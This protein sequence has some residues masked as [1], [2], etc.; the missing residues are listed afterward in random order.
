MNRRGWLE[1]LGMYG[2]LTLVNLIWAPEQL[3]FPKAAPHPYVLPILIT[4]SRYGVAAGLWASL[5][6]FVFMF[7]LSGLAFAFPFHWYSSG[8][9]INLQNMLDHPRNLV[10]A[11]WVLWSAAVGSA[12]EKV[13]RE[14]DHFS[15]E[16]EHLQQTHAEVKTRN[17]LLS[18]ENQELREK[19]LGKGDTVATV[20]E[21]A[22]RLT[23]LRGQDLYVACLELVEKFVGSERSCIYL[24]SKDRR[25]LELA[26]SRT[27]E[28][29]PAPFEKE[30]GRGDPLLEKCLSENRT[31]SVRELFTAQRSQQKIPAV[32]SAPLFTEESGTLG[33]LVLEVLPI[34]SLNAQT[35]SVLELLADW[36]SRSL[37]VVHQFERGDDATEGTGSLAH[38]LGRRRLS[39]TAFNTLS[40]YEPTLKMAVRVLADPKSHAIAIWNSARLVATAN[41]QA[42]PAEKAQLETI[43]KNLLDEGSRSVATRKTLPVRRKLIG[44]QGLRIRLQ[45]LELLK[46]EAAGLLLKL[47]LEKFTK[48]SSIDLLKQKQHLTPRQL[49][50]SLDGLARDVAFVEAEKKNW[51]FALGLNRPLRLKVSS[52]ELLQTLTESQDHWTQRL[53]H[54][55]LTE[56]GL[57]DDS[58]AL[59][60]MLES[61]YP[62]DIEVAFLAL[63]QID[64]G[65]LQVWPEPESKAQQVALERVKT[66]MCGPASSGDAH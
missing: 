22:R 18:T 61:K 45:K 32:L 10:F 50:L 60:P 30:L 39:R 55:A 48:Q 47:Y 26:E 62:L 63:G 7:A 54:L 20:Y 57:R 42:V 11:T 66:E 53:A 19:V 37:A 31:V 51:E 17:E 64:P 58:S 38:Q 43:I 8:H 33:V 24:L 21:M 25:C 46:F 15:Q 16:L 59:H 56:L 23:T 1:M 3:G 9:Q 13:R 65:I 36:T 28:P 52:E 4:A 29:S 12:L 35:V 27:S 49:Q 6:G 44:C 40:H 34:E 41:A 5:T 2:L 14:R